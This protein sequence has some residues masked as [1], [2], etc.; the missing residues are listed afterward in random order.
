M[1]HW[2]ICNYMAWKVIIFHLS[3]IVK[4]MMKNGEDFHGHISFSDTEI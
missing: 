1:A 4:G 2:K 3:T